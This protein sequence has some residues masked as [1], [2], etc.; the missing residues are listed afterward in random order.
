[1]RLLDIEKIEE[2]KGTVKF[3]IVH[4]N[5]T[6]IT[7]GKFKKRMSNGV[8][9][10]SVSCPEVSYDEN[11][12]FIV[13]FIR[14]RNKRYDNDYCYCDLD[15]YMEIVDAINELNSMNEYEDVYE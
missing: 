3:K 4:Q 7:R 5:D 11:G 8:Y 6:L 1:M 14:G 2:Y 12:S 13:F 10:E 15:T 9:I